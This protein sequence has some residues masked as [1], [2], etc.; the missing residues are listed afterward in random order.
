MVNLNAMNID[1]QDTVEIIDMCYASFK[2]NMIKK[3]NRPLLRG[4]NIFVPLEWNQFKAEAFW[5]AASTEPN[6]IFN[7]FPCNNDYSYT[8]CDSNCINE[9]HTIT[10]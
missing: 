6:K 4:K 8:L 9:N 5:H 3:E 1:S 2:E 7:I 10:F